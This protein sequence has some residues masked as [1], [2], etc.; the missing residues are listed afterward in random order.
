MLS[1]LRSGSALAS[2]C[3][4]RGSTPD[5]GMYDGHVITKSGRWV[6]SGYS[7]FLP[8]KRWQI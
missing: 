6:S 8:Q 2:H 4:N 5:L 7:G 1:D 3:Y